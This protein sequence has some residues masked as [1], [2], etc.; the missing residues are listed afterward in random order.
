M[1]TVKF[2]KFNFNNKIDPFQ[3]KMKIF[4]KFMSIK[5]F[6][7]IFNFGITTNFNE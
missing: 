2:V 6:L 4:S 1:H 3:M 5:N 7:Y